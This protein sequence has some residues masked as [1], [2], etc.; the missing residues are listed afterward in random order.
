MSEHA[1]FAQRLSFHPRECFHTTV[2]PLAQ[3]AR[4]RAFRR[5]LHLHARRCGRHHSSHLVQ[6]CVHCRVRCTSAPAKFGAPFNPFSLKSIRATLVFSFLKRRRWPPTRRSATCRSRRTTAAQQ[7]CRQHCVRR[8]RRRL[9]CR[10][11]QRRRRRH[12][13]RHRLTAAGQQLRRRLRHRLR[14]PLMPTL[15]RGETVA[16]IFLCSRACVFSFGVLCFFAQRMYVCMLTSRTQTLVHLSRSAAPSRTAASS[17]SGAASVPTSR[18]G[19]RA[20]GG[21]RLG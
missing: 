11:A 3:H 16:R 12:H 21:R 14:L 1:S 6:R 15:R 5:T 8:R 10:R 20:T 19:M 2:R 7:Q 4:T 18:G 17:R 13:R 9:R